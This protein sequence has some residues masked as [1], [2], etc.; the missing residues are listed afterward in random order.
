[1]T[2]DPGLKF[3]LRLKGVKERHKKLEPRN[4]IDPETGRSSLEGVFSERAQT[5]SCCHVERIDPG[6]KHG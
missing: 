4:K 2:I 5:E 3:A 6:E 1:M